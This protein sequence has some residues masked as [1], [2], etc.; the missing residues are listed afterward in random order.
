MNEFAAMAIPALGTALV[1]FLWQG[2]LL[3]LL[4]ALALGLLRNARPQARYAVACAALA[5]SLLLPASTLAWLLAVPTAEPASA[6]AAI[7]VADP[8]A[9]GTI[10]A[11]DTLATQAMTS[12]PWIVMAW[13]SGVATLLLRMTG[14]LWWVRRLRRERVL[15]A[16]R[17]R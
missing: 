1:H 11:Q 14:G 6:L 2:V 7:F 3:G 9:S 10:G 16:D 13:A 4:A 12:L 8:T 15:R 5:M 17:A